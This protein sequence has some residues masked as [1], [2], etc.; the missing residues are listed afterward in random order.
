MRKFGF[1]L[2]LTALLLQACVVKSNVKLA[3]LHEYVLKSNVLND[4]TKVGGLSGIDYAN[5][6]YYIVVD[7]PKAP[8][9]LKASI[10]IKNKR[11]DTIV[12]K[13]ALYLKNIDSNNYLD[14]ESIFIDLAKQQ[15]NFT[16]E[17]SINKNKRPLIFTTDFSGNFKNEVDL[18]K[19]FQNLSNIR[20]NGVF[21]GSSKDIAHN[22]FWVAMEAPL[23][24]DGEEPKFKTTQ[25]PVRITYF[26]AFSRKA[27]KQ[28]AYELEPITKPAK[29]NVNVNGVT[30][31]LAYATNKFLIIERTYQSNYGAYGNIIRIFD[32]E[33]TKNTSNILNTTALQN[34]R[35][36]PIKKRLLLDFKDYKDKLTEGIIDNIEGITFGPELENGNVSL[37]L[38]AD[39]NFK[40]YGKQLNQFIL[41]EMIK[42]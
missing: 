25:S 32:A 21:E 17:G 4:S 38:V 14:L 19:S 29:G 31:I 6:F 16:S 34:T 11:I 33:I 1:L 28:F 26:D 30:A 39:D 5:N 22:G 2:F 13:K 24:S 8:R 15:I 23:K 35:Y 42:K 37:I 7:D 9:F 36:I 3:F 20:H 12:F 41:L 18:P 10:N 27:T 40:L